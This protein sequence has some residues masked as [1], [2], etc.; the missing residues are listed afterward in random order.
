MSVGGQEWC[1]MRMPLGALPFGGGSVRNR[2][3]IVSVPID[4]SG[5]RVLGS[6]V[7]Y[8]ENHRAVRTW[9]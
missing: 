7:E 6:T 4:G 2:T 1:R 8:R 3:T 9:N 5:A